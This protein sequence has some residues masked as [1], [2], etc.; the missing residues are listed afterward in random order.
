MLGFFL[1]PLLLAALWFGAPLLQRRSFRQSPH[2]NRQ[3]TL[4]IEREGLRG[5]TLLP[6]SQI[7][8]IEESPDH[9]FIVW[10]DNRLLIVPKRA[11]DSELAATQFAA[12][13]R[14]GRE[15]ALP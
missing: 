6:W 15:S 2:H 1:P 11:F 4:S 10:G 13:C 12:K 7:H 5:E 9:I 3:M 8:S 14:D